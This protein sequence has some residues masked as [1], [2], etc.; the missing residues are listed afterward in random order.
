MNEKEKMI[1]GMNYNPLDPQLI[2]LR[3][4]ASR[5]CHRY[6]KKTFHEVNLRSRLLRKLL[7]TEGNFWVK[8]PFYCDYGFNI[9]LGNDVMLNYGCVLLDVCPI[10]IGDKTLIGP[11]VQLLTACHSL[12]PKLREQD[13]EFGKPITIGRNVWIGGGAIVCPGVTIRDNTVIGAGS[14]VTKSM[15]ANVIAY[16]NPCRVQRRIDPDQKPDEF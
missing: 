14:V 7:R 11:N 8:P 9:T 2:L 3:D 15:P 12:D 13:V 16:G 4:R 10:T 1:A 5:L 6:N